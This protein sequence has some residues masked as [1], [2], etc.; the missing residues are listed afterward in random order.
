MGTADKGG[1]RFGGMGTN[2]GSGEGDGA[3]RSAELR[4]V[5]T[6]KEWPP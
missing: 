1:M 5:R 2:D 3:E 6:S 4:D